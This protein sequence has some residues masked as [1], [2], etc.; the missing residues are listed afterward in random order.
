MLLVTLLGACSDP[1]VDT[2]SADEDRGGADMPAWCAEDHRTEVTDPA[3]PADGFSF[4]AQAILDAALGDF[5]GMLDFVQLDRP[6]VTTTLSL[7]RTDAPIEA[8]YFVMEGGTGD[9]GMASGAPDP[10]CE[11]RYEVPAAGT[12]IAEDLLA[13]TLDLSLS[14]ARAESATFTLSLP[15]ADVNGAARPVDI[16]PEDW[17]SVTLALDAHQDAG[18]W[19][20]SLMWQASSE[21]STARRTGGS[22]ARAKDEQAETG[23]TGVSG[24]VEGYGSFT[25]TRP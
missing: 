9:T 19:L 14:A 20:G 8:V 24:M 23:A 17:A 18:A 12:L 22:T 1:K 11:S 16:V 15:L 6:K 10:L 4:S 13:E 5:T 7:T 25:L 3:T 21:A 2:A